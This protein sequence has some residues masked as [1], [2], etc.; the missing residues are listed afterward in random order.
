MTS[1]EIFDA[2]K[3]QKKQIDVSEG[4]SNRVMANVHR[5]P[6]TRTAGYLRPLFGGVTTRPWARAAVLAAGVIF[7]LARILATIHL[8]LSV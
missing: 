8:V 4:F 7:G 3:T 2:W 1:Q 5:R 6:T